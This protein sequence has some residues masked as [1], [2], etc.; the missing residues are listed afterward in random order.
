MKI[1]I[2][3]GVPYVNGEVVGWADIVVSIAGVPVTGITGVEYEDDQ[4]VNAVYGAGRYPV[5]YGKGRITC[6]GKITLLQEEVVSIQRQ[7]PSGRLQDIAP[8]NITV[9][10]LPANGMIV[11]DKLRNCLFSKNSR[12][13]KEGDAKQE[14]DLDLI[15]SHIEWHNK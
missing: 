12:S 7:A 5:G 4:E 10:Y 6:K 11:T 3:N 1:Q 9:S 8:F 13:W 14:I 15:M 2:K